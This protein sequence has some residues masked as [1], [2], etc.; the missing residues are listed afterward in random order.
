[1]KKTKVDYTRLKDEVMEIIEI[2][3]K[4][5]CETATRSDVDRMEEIASGGAPRAEFNIG[6][7][8]YCGIQREPS[9]KTAFEWFDRC[10][11]H[12]GSEL[13]VQLCYVYFTNDRLKE[14]NDCVRRMVHDD[15]KMASDLLKEIEKRWPDKVK[16]YQ[17]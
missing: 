12:A 9:L 4:L 2:E 1:M 5:Q 10:R 7:C 13:Q 8:N 11:M 17:A 3:R 14:A 6:M 16:E 15:P